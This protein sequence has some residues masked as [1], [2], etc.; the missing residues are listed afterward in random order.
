MTKGQ[1]Y[2]ECIYF[3]YE[4]WQ[5]W[6]GRYNIF[7]GTDIYGLDFK[8][9]DEAKIFIDEIREKGGEIS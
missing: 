8:D 2:R 9:V 4:I 1:D 7:F 5:S 3:G 6:N